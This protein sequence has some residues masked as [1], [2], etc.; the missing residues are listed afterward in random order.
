L[1]WTRI[2]HVVTSAEATA[3]TVRIQRQLG[4]GAHLRIVNLLNSVTLWLPTTIEIMRVGAPS[5]TT[6][7]LSLLDRRIQPGNKDVHWEGS[8]PLSDD[9][10]VIRGTI[11]GPTAADAI[12]LT[13]GYE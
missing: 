3:G 6:E 2:R 12:Y 10:R 9:F 11:L 5:D 1:E 4:L 13:V 7:T 8:L